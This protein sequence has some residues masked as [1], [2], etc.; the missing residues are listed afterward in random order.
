MKWHWQAMS[1][2]VTPK[3]LDAGCFALAACGCSKAVFTVVSPFPPIKEIAIETSAVLTGAF[4]IQ[5]FG[6]IHEGF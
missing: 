6:T 1:N 2:C 3:T 4:T 5:I